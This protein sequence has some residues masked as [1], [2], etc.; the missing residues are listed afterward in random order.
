M[1]PRSFAILALATA[2]SVGLAIHAVADRDAPVRVQTAGEPLFPGL[3]DRLNE[4][5]EV[6][7]ATPE[8][9]LTVQSANQGWTLA[10]KSGYPVDPA[11]VRELAL[12]LA[13]LQLLESKTADSERLK[14]LELEEPG[15]EGA[16]S[17]RV[18]LVGAEGA[19]LAA[20]V[21]GKGSPSLYGGG[22]GGV[23]VR[24]GGENQSW[25]A[26]GEID[27]PTD[28][29]ALLDSEVVDVPEAQVARVVV[30]PPGAPAATLSRASA[31][32]EFTTDA[33]LPEGRK[34]DPVKVESLSGALAGLTMSDVRPAA[35]LT[36]G[37]D[38][39]RLRF[40][41]FAGGAVDVTMTVVG[42]GDAAEHWLTLA[43]T[44]KLAESEAEPAE[45]QADHGKRLDGWAF[46]VPSYMADRLDEGLD[47]L[48]ADPSPAS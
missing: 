18:E 17:R 47:E 32:A 43:A 19:P 23:Y 40:E 36:F 7:I 29:L 1:S 2:A 14:R 42:E 35:E 15:G 10:E 28:A 31:E 41:T 37:P 27:L 21:I 44:G 30:Q 38:A 24:R 46:K 45:P 25:L 11:K 26:A 4:V 16:K 9:K 33:A 34:L 5:R 22:R 39:R 48:L 6:R 8:G 13:N 20:A 12:A 3:L